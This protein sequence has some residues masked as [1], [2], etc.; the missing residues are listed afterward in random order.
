MLRVHVASH[1]VGARNA[2]EFCWSRPIFGVVAS[3]AIHD[4][5]ARNAIEK[6]LTSSKFWRSCECRWSRYWLKKCDLN[7]LPKPWICCECY[8]SRY[9]RENIQSSV[10]ILARYWR[11]KCDWK[12]FQLYLVP[13]TWLAALGKSLL[14]SLLKECQHISR[15]NRD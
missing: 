1:S 9:W 15:Q 12:F 7:F 2:I 8:Q 13:I 11:E 3:A 14:G 5:G 10:T 4:I 6:L